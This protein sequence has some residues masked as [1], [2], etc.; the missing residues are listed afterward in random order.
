MKV[1]LQKILDQ[2]NAI[3]T[4]FFLAVLV[5]LLLMP[6]FAHEDIFSTYKRAENIAFHQQTLFVSPDVIPHLVEA[7]N[8]RVIS[9]FIPHDVIHQIHGDFRQITE[10]N[11]LLFFFKLLYLIAECIFWYILFKYFINKTVGN[12]LLVLFNPI[13]L[14]SVYMFG[15]YETFVLLALILLLYSLKVKSS[16]LF[17]IMISLLPIVRFSLVMTLPAVLFLK[18]SI[19]EKILSLASSGFVILLYF[20]LN[21]VFSNAFQVSEWVSGGS[22]S[23]YFF[24]SIIDLDFGFILYI[25]VVLLA[26][27]IGKLISFYFENIHSSNISNELLFSVVSFSILTTYYVFSIFHPQYL[28]WILPFAFY[29][30]SKMKVDF[31]IILYL[32]S[33]LFIFIPLKWGN[34]TTV[35]LLF[36]ISN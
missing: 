34:A 24:S 32:I 4:I 9:I 10:V 28:V 1:H 11:T 13:V 29:L 18:I 27:V 23:N 31:K 15:R 14:Y 3:P 17:M 25:S 20:V 21:K 35:M 8:L 16:K 19:R 5:R 6:F 7:I 12:Y 36:P 33:F 22:H 2:I 26:F 30:V